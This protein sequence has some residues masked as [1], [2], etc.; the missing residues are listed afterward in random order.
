M[1]LILLSY[2]LLT[3]LIQK[4]LKY[5]MKYLGFDLNF[6]SIFKLLH[7]PNLFNQVCQDY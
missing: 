6:D 5:M 1:N 3:Y 7:C 2:A 4:I